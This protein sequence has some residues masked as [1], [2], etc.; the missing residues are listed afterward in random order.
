MLK[1]RKILSF[2]LAMLICMGWSVSYAQTCKIQDIPQPDWEELD[3]EITELLGQLSKEFNDFASVDRTSFEFSLEYFIGKGEGLELG[4]Y[5]HPAVK[6]NYKLDKK[7]S[8]TQKLD[9]ALRDISEYISTYYRTIDG[10]SIDYEIFIKSVEIIVHYH[11]SNLNCDVIYTKYASMQYDD[12]FKISV[13]VKRK[14]VEREKDP[15]DIHTGSGHHIMIG[16]IS[17]IILKK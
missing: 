15:E 3:D 9:I 12:E 11:L 10:E 16:D 7:N 8:R 17:I 13:D 4:N 6:M 14:I 1:P 2:I 5:I